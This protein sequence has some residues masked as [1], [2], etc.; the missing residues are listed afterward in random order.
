MVRDSLKALFTAAHLAAQTAGRLPAG[1]L[2]DFDLLRP[3]Q[4]EHGDYSCNVAMVAA[5]AVRKAG[6]NLNPRQVAQA[7]VDN[8]PAD[9]MLASVEIAGPGFI[10]LRLA[11]GWLQQQVAAI[12][13]AGDS[14]ANNSRGLGQRWQVEYV[15]ANP[16]GPIHYGGARNAC[17]GDAVA[18]V[19]E[20]SG[21]D[22]QREYYV[23]DGGS[24][25]AQ[26]IETLYVRIMQALGHDLP[27]PEKGY[28]GEY[29]LDYATLVLQTHGDALAA[30]P[31]DEALAAL[32]PIG[33]ELVVSKLQQELARI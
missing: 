22:V 8:L 16:T 24:Q 14:F 28:V 20:A 26:F 2:P 23:N 1:T 4:P 11:N 18:N 25:F 7:L 13:A 27:L 17:L 6:G 9:T 10:N 5:A 19:L 30:L 21:Y 32:R 15:S 33:R 12:V 31:R 3:K 29:M